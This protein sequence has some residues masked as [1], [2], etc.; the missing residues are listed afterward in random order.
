M[1]GGNRERNIEQDLPRGFVEKI[2]V[3]EAH[4]GAAHDERHRAGTIG[5]LRVLADQIEQALHVGHRLLDLAIDDAEEVERH[6][7]LQHE[8]VHQHEVADRHVAG[9]DAGGRTPHDERYRDGNDRALPDVE[10]GERRLAF[11]RRFFPALQALVVALRLPLLVAEILDR[12]VVEQA[13]DR[14]CVRLRV[15]LVHLAPE[16]RPPF[17]D[18]DREGDIHG[19]RAR[20]DR[21]ERPVVP[22][23]QDGGHE[24]DFDQCRQDRKEREA[25][26]RGNAALTAFHVARQTARLPRKME[27]HRERMQVAK[28]LQPDLA[29]GALRDFGEQEFAEL[30]KRRRGQPQQPVGHEQHQRNGQYRGAGVEAVDDL[31]HQHRHADVG[32]L[33][34]D[35]ASERRQDA[36]LVLP[37]I[38]NERRDRM[39]IAAR[40][41]RDAGVSG[42]R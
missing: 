23:D 19:K 29:H 10:R 21:H 36:S 17:G 4:L 37:E 32:H 41:A 6:I 14:A 42:K 24:R 25:D 22:G 11:H 13:V 5:D 33:C 7:K 2:D 39:P 35:Q 15:E 8:A 1:S 9:D 27:T 38:G 40:G 34:G 12:F 28:H 18:R 30:G 3:L 26:E 31:F 16:M 20:G